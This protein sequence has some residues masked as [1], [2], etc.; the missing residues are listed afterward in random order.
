MVQYVLKRADVEG[1]IAFIPP[2]DAGAVERIKRELR[3][4]RDRHNDH[5]LVTIQP[6]KR[7]RTTG[8]R[9]QNRHLNG[10]VMQICRETGND[11][12]T[13]KDAVKR[14]A[15]ERFGYPLS[16]VGAVTVPKRERE[17]SA[18]E[19]AKLIEAAHMLAADLGII[20]N[21]GGT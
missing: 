20:L 12:D 21:E 9:S 2:D 7:P 11:F 4:C 10:H 13:V 17:C 6:P 1:R 14:I 15:A 5:A 19:C 16:T 18:G 8:P 3:G